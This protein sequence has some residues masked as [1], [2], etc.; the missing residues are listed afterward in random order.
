MSAPRPA[1][2][3]K[4]REYYD[5]AAEAVPQFSVLNYGFSCEPENSV[6]AANEPEFAVLVRD[7]RKCVLS[8][9]RSR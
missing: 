5:R 3:L 8:S 4:H 7:V 9:E 6:L 1:A 2:T